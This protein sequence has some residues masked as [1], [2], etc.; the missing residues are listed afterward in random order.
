MYST[1]NPDNREE[2]F[3]KIK[4]DTMQLVKCRPHHN[5]TGITNNTPRLVD[6]FL[7]DF[8]IPF[9]NT[10]SPRNFNENLNLKVD[11]YEKDDTVIIEAELPGVEKE[12]LYV[13]TKGK[14]VTLGGERKSDEKI[15]D[16]NSYRRERKYGKF[17]RT[18]NLPFEIST[19]RVTATFNNG[20]LKLEIPKP[21]EETTSK[22][23]I[24]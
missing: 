10:V 1:I 5:M 14:L 17:E 7:D 9:T 13:D 21:E 4:G 2:K 24:Q 8:F 18:F 19:D 22:I 6:T 3:H 12:D 15:T 11:I 20:I 16:E 23:A